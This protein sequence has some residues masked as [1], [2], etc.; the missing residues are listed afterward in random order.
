MNIYKGYHY[1]LAYYRRNNYGQP[2]MWIALPFDDEC[3]ELYHGIVGKKINRELVR[4][5]R[6]VTDEIRSRINA[7]RKAGYKLLCEIKD[8]NSLPVEGELLPF[9]DKYLPVNR[10]NADNLLLPMLAKTY[11]PKVFNKNAKFI[12][13]YK[14]NGLRC[15]VSAKQTNDIFQTRHLIFTSREGTVWN[16]L[17][18]LES[19]LLDIIPDKFFNR[20]IDENIILDGEIYLPN[21]SVNEINH[22]VKDAHCYENKLLQFWCYDLAVEE[23]TQL[24]RQE[25][26]NK[27]FMGHN[28]VF[29]NKDD[30]YNNRDRL[31]IL[32]NF[33]VINN[34]SAIALR[35]RFIDVGFE[36]LIM[37]NPDAEYQ[38]GKRNLSMIKFKSTDDGIFE[39][40][41][42]YPEG[43]KRNNIPLIQLKN[44][45]NDAT[46]EVH[47]NGSFEYQENVLKNKEQYIGKRI[48]LTY[49]ERSGVNKVPFHIKEV[50]LYDL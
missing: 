13:Q 34:E 9:L 7:K 28:H 29:G 24:S 40:I 41:D 4:T 15:F 39:I 27:V 32:P 1:N 2:C 8:S 30:H 3:I 42:I 5:H 43:I 31:I 48:Y 12:G 49:G 17:S 22:F 25:L 47:L 14:I 23:Y 35:N 44:D 46:F 50:K 26:L 36:G 11:T 18:N 45:I 6:N 21:H 20:M 19:Y 16:S 10:T 37:R 38:Y 33:S